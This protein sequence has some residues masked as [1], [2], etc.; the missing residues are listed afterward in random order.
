MFFNDFLCGGFFFSWIFKVL[1]AALV[2][3]LIVH[4]FSKNQTNKSIQMPPETALDIL[5]RR[6]AK[7]EIS[8]EQYEQMRKDLE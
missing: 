2:I 7:G 6:Y 8:K 5:K 3:W 4:T 1:V